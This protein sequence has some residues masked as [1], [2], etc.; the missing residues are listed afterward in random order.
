MRTHRNRRRPTDAISTKPFFSKM[1]EKPSGE[2]NAPS[3]FFQRNLAVGA[4]GDRLEQ[5]AETTADAVMPRDGGTKEGMEE[6]DTIHRL[7]EQE[8]NL[9]TQNEDQDPMQLGNHEVQLG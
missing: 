6:K 2:S 4:S 3:E 7:A 9:Q 5:E 8:E 1:S